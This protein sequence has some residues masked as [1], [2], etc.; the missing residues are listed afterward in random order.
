LQ[1]RR[2]V[3]GHSLANLQVGNE[4][5]LDYSKITVLFDWLDRSELPFLEL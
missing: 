3:T 5:T 4:R 1:D 2:G